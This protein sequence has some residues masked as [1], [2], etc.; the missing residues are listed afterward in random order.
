[1]NVTGLRLDPLDTLFF[2]DGR[3]FDAA[4]RVSTGLPHPQPLAGAVRTDLLA[5]AGLDLA[6]FARLRREG[7][8]ERAALERLRAPEWVLDLRFRGPWLALAGGGV[9]EPLLPVP[10][11]LARDDGAWCRSDPLRSKLPGWDLQRLPLWRRG[12]A[13]AKHPGGFLTPAGVEKFLAGGV[14]A[15]ADWLR[16]E[17]LFG[18]DNRTG[19]EIDPATLTAAEGRIYGIRLLSLRPKLGPGRHEGKEVCLYAEALGLPEGEGP[20]D[21]LAL[22]GEGR[23]VRVRKLDRPP[24]WGQ[25]V[26]AEDRS[27]WLLAAPAF[28]PGA[29]ALPE[30]PGPAR[31]VAAASG[32]PAAFSGW[33]VARG[34]P[35]PA[36]FAVPAGAVYFVEGPFDPTNQTLCADA[37]DAAQGWGFVLRGT[38]NHA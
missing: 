22:G 33:D 10:A 18:F 35:R 17:E 25:P 19:I 26:P 4:T 15:D 1:M 37:E 38:W 9:V 29:D 11:T 28:L 6:V 2:R 23:Y 5:R 36:R 13:D 34:R 8:G 32:P 30:V 31:L 24:A 7:L 14:P 3:P 21:P 20:S 27:L 16:S 12:G